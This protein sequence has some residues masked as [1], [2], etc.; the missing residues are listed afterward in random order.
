MELRER[1]AE[2]ISMRL[3]K[4]SFREIGERFD[5]SLERVR[6]IVY[7][8]RNELRAGRHPRLSLRAWWAIGVLLSQHNT[9]ELLRLDGVGRT[10]L[11]EV[12]DF[13]HRRGFWP[14][15]NKNGFFKKE[16]DDG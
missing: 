10:T 14:Q 1:N 3:D 12:V 4:A 13:M 7:K 9:I 2:I 5:I 16:S 6:Q 15:Y 11:R 8:H